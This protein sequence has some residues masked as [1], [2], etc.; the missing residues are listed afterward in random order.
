[1]R[2]ISLW[3]SETE[4]F[5]PKRA[6]LRTDTEKSCGQPAPPRRVRVTPISSSLRGATCATSAT[7][8]AFESTVARRGAARCR[9]AH[10]RAPASRRSPSVGTSH[11][12]REPTISRS[13]QWASHVVHVRMT[14]IYIPEAFRTPGAV[15]HRPYLLASAHSQINSGKT[16]KRYD[17][18]VRS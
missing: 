1:M 11:V 9:T 15:T 13:A 18:Y 5:E 12:G 4:H 8:V 10:R 3:M 14:H 7:F 17:A 2:V 16:Y 6:W